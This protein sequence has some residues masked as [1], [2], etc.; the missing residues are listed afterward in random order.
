MGAAAAGDKGVV[1][2]FT[3]QGAQY[4]GMGWELYEQ[5]KVFREEVDRCSELLRG[6]LGVDLRG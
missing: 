2:L 6:E 3:G 4:E 1:Y 5:E